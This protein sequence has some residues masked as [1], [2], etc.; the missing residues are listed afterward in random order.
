ME[1][2]DDSPMIEDETSNDAAY[3]SA[4]D[5]IEIGDDSDGGNMTYRG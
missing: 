5:S 4:I 1:I 2:G 3:S